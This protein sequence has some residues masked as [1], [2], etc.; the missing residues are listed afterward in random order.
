VD[1]IGGQTDGV[2]QPIIAIALTYAAVIA[3]VRVSGLRSFAK[4]SAFDFAATI[5]AGSLIAS[6]AV[7]SAPLWSGVAA[8]A[9]LFAA[10]AAVAWVRQREWGHRLVDNRPILLMDGGEV[11]REN[12]A[13]AG[14]VEADL[15]AQLRVAGVRRSDHVRAVVLETSGDVSV[16]EGEGGVDGLDPLLRTDLRR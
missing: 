9:G 13:R 12:L 5:A 6:A 14:L 8:L 10:Q 15:A 4:M 2:L 3:L 1:L 7:G 16:I 11:L